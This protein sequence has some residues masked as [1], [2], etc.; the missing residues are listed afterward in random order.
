[1]ST[2][3]GKGLTLV[4]GG[5]GFIGRQIVEALRDEG[6]RV[7]VLDC[8][9][10]RKPFAADV[11]PVQGSILDADVLSTAMAGVETVFH[12]AANAQ[13]WARRRRDFEE[14]NHMGTRGVIEAA[15]AAGARRFIHVSSLTVLVGKHLGRAPITL[16]EEDR[17]LTAEEMLG[18]YPRTKWHGEK[19]A[20]AS[21]DE[22]FKVTAVLP[23][24]PLGPGDHGLT[25][26]TQMIV[27][28]VNGKTPAYLDCVHNFVDVRDL[29]QAMLAARDRGAP[30]ERYLLGGQNVTM[31]DLLKDLKAMT[32]LRMP[33]ARAPYPLALMAGMMS[34]VVSTMVTGRPPKAPLTGVRLA[35]RRIYF[36]SAKAKDDLGFAP[37]PYPE[38]LRD[39]LIWARE[40]GHISRS[41]RALDPAA[42]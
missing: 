31:R 13:L 37:R 12:A 14:I 8:A 32:Q 26:P 5:A 33:T 19:A 6:R 41:V 27:D 15:R 7:R 35:G 36:D 18:A 1:M 4:T 42:A 40:E 2:D 17:G 11:E 24:M 28:L 34:E 9:A 16:T 20:L 39:A 25:A 3:T 10:P 23:T 22:H 21:N 29:A 30:G 38:A